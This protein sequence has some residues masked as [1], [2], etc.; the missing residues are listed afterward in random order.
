MTNILVKVKLEGISNFL[1]VDEIEDV[2]ISKTEDLFIGHCEKDKL[3][4]K[5]IGSTIN[6]SN[7]L[8]NRIN[9]PDREYNF[10]FL[11]LLNDR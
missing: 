6:V 5:Q 4:I 3:I 7:F 2:I 11:E 9:T 1:E 10:S 8:L